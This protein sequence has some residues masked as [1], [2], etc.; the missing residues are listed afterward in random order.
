MRLADIFILSRLYITEKQL[1]SLDNVESTEYLL[2]QSMRSLRGMTWGGF[3]YNL[4]SDEGKL[5]P[6]STTVDTRHDCGTS[7]SSHSPSVKADA[8]VHM[9][10]NGDGAGVNE[11]VFSPGYKQSSTASKKEKQDQHVEQLSK[12]LSNLHNVSVSIGESL[13]EHDEI[14]NSLTDKTNET[15][16]YALTVTLRAAQLTQRTTGS[17]AVLVGEYKFKTMHNNYLSVFDESITLTPQF[18]WST[19]FRVYSKENHLYALQNVK[20]R[21]FLGLNF[22]GGVVATSTGFGKNQEMFI[23]LTGKT[24][25]MFLASNWGNGGWLKPDKNGLLRAVSKSLVDRDD[26][27]LLIPIELTDA[28]YKKLKNL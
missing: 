24:G 8:S 14:A 11:N 21:R 27:L 20:T 19:V 7:E 25:I 12:S 2:Q 10:S 26:R 1:T 4:V 18:N 9:Y 13:A 22:F 28:D 16:D 17:Q 15:N 5:K 23:D 3:F 6:A